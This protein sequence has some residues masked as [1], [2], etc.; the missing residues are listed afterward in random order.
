[1]EG[2]ANCVWEGENARELGREE[3]CF[4]ALL[5]T[6]LLFASDF[7]QLTVVLLILQ[8]QLYFNS[9]SPAVVYNENET[10]IDNL[11]TL[12]PTQPLLWFA[13]F[14]LPDEKFLH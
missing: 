7:L 2:V 13:L 11:N 3:K 9:L 6:P 8:Q 4:S 12:R 5:L 14:I 10:T 1:M